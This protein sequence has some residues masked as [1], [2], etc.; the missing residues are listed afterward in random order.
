MALKYFTYEKDNGETS[1]RCVFV[2][3]P[4][5]DNMLTIDL[6]EFI[7]E[8]RDY[9]EAELTR[10]HNEFLENIEE[11]GLKRNWRSF[12]SKGIKPLKGD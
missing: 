12:K 6:S 10:I 1:D 2:I 5:S 11:I 8:E 9:Y 3:S 4:A 7:P